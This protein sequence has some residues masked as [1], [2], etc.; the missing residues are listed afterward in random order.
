M[1]LKV[2]FSKYAKNVEF[3]TGLG[4]LSS[5]IYYHGVVLLF[6]SSSVNDTAKQTAVTKCVLLSLMSLIQQLVM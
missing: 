2:L 6:Q 3:C 5:F 4:N 1:V